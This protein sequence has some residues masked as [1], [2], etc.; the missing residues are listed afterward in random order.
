MSLSGLQ[1]INN[2]HGG[3]NS[4]T[5]MFRCFNH[6][7][8]HEPL[9]HETLKSPGGPNSATFRL[10]S[11]AYYIYI[12]IYVKH[13]ILYSHIDSSIMGLRMSHSYNQ[14]PIEF[15]EVYHTKHSVWILQS[16]YCTYVRCS[17]I[18]HTQPLGL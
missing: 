18:T 17:A 6:R 7:I 9:R 15:S 2:P 4:I 14:T 8:A 10:S 11:K 5:Y 16:W 12:R 13:T 1:N 3:P